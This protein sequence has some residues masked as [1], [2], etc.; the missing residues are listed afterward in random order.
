MSAEGYLPLIIVTFSTRKKNMSSDIYENISSIIAEFKMNAKVAVSTVWVAQHPRK[1]WM[2]A[3]FA[4]KK[5]KKIML[6]KEHC[7]KSM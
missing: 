4:K 5:E 1:S 2:K 6:M 7:L 3:S